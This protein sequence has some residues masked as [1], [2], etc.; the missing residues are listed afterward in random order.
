MT[1]W[2]R[3]TSRLVLLTLTLWFGA[4]LGVPPLLRGWIETQA[5]QALGRQV[6]L[7]SVNVLPW[8]LEV[9]LQGLTVGRLGAQPGDTPQF[10]LEELYADLELQSLL[11]LAPVV[12]ALEITAPQLELTHL[13]NGKYDVDDVLADLLRPSTGPTP[14]FAAYNIH[15]RAGRVVLRDDAAGSR[16]TLE[17]LDLAIPFLS[18]LDAQR[19]IST[20]PRLSFRLN[21]SHFETAADTT[22]FADNRRTRADLRLAG[23]DLQP[24]LAYWPEVLP[25]RISSGVLDASVSIAFEQREQ[26]SIILSGDLALSGLNIQEHPGQGAPNLPLLQLERIHLA[27]ADVRP[28][29]NRYEFK[30]LSVLAPQL[31][32]RRNSQGVLHLVRISERLRPGTASASSDRTNSPAA[33]TLGALRLEAGRLLWSDQSVQPA[34]RLEIQDIGFTA[35]ALA[36]PAAQAFPFKGQARLGQAQ[37]QGSGES[38]LQSA[39]MQMSLSNLPVQTFAPYLN[40][41]LARPVA[42]K[43]S[44]QGQVRWQAPVAAGATGVSVDVDRLELEQPAMGAGSTPEAAMGR[45]AVSGLRGQMDT[46]ELSVRRVHLVQPRL[47]LA[48]NAQGRW[49]FEDWLSAQPAA[50]P[51]VTPSRPWDVRL[52]E[53]WI[54]RGSVHLRDATVGAELSVQDLALRLGHMRPGTSRQLTTPLEGS[55]RLLTAQQDSGSLSLKGQL[56]LPAP[57]QTP[58]PLTW[59]GRVDA[60]DLPAHA[61]EPYLA[62]LLNFEL[63]KAELNYAGEVVLALPAQGLD[64][65]LNGDLSLDDLRA[66]T[67]SPDEPLLDWKTLQ[68]RGV[69]T[70]VTAGKLQR[71]SVSETVLSDF[72][73]RIS[74][75]KDGRINLQDLLRDTDAAPSAAVAPVIAFGP[76]RL[77][78]GRVHFSDRF[79][80]PNYSA[81]LSELSGSL[82]AF[83]NQAAGT[84]AAPRLADLAL[85]GRAEG[86]ATLAIAGKLNPLVRPLALDVRAQAKDLELPPLSPYSGKYAGYG[87][88]RGKLSL[89]VNY[90]V[91]PS[92]QLTASNQIMLNQLTFGERIEG[93]QAPSLPLKLA[94]ALLSDSKGMIDINIP[95]SGSINEPEFRLWPVIGRV[96]V[97]LVGKALTA[98]FALLSGALGGDETQQVDFAPGSSDLSEQ[99]RL[100]L[101]K[102][103]SALRDRPGL[104]LTVEGHSD[105]GSEAEHWRRRKLDTQVQAERRRQALSSGQPVNETLSVTPA[106]YAVLLKEVYRRSDIRKP[107]NLVGM[108]KELPLAEMENLLLAAIPVGESDMRELALARGVAVKD[109]LAGQK[110]AADRLFLGHSS[111]GKTEGAKATANHAILTVSTQ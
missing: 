39:Q 44:L 85:Q 59:S 9:R 17:E 28:L 27:M 86:S 62:G 3:W 6:Q 76:M 58:Q 42:G 108:A 16:H 63:Q 41:V 30:T 93:S 18:N 75:A 110:V 92:G 82:S 26:P 48:R 84:E 89:D 31:H 70:E 5:S 83:S 61:L 8:T 7:S 53:V 65:R 107:R 15:V 11:R 57:G 46:R 97:N 24:Y 13:G 33:F 60:V 101:D 95:I 87:I 55:L 32:V 12:D 66:S 1:V 19:N 54:D 71:L 29:E 72:F 50:S 14:R 40:G 111:S 47:A 43:L 35:D 22:P 34:A 77:Q 100:R 102:L 69:Q 2:I 21:G 38:D 79:V 106:Q 56:R 105:L 103:A 73:A 99:A 78:Q 45:L 49:M 23:M 36:L 67:R 90:R 96:I 51:A 81:K 64:L 94:V 91:E 68:L 20:H 88:E 74:V 4:W 109:F 52:D 10:Q 25:L 98:P 37:W 104:R 80:Q